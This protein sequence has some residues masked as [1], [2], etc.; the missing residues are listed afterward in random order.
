MFDANA[1]YLIAQMQLIANEEK[2]RKELAQ[3]IREAE[4]LSLYKIRLGKAKN[5]T[6]IIH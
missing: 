6:G 4:E 2:R 5:V 3:N 1:G